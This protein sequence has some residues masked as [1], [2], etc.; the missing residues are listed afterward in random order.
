[1]PHAFN[2]VAYKKEEGQLQK[3]LP[4]VNTTMEVSIEYPI[5]SL[6]GF[7]DKNEQQNLKNQVGIVQYGKLENLFS[8]VPDFIAWEINNNLGGHDWVEFHDIRKDIWSGGKKPNNIINN[9][10]INA[11]KNL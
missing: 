9:N 6:E 3:Q 4:N 2:T 7:L 10:F 11:V 1:M 8:N 5:N